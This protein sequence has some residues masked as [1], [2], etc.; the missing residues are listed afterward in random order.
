MKYY[1][2]TTVWNTDYA[3]PNH[4]YYMRDDKQY[5]VGYIPV[6]S[7]KLVKFRKPMRIETKGRKFTV[8]P[9]AGEDDSVYFGQ[10]SESPAAGVITVEGSG[11]KKYYLSKVGSGW[12]CTCPGY[13][14]RR[15]CR[16]VAEQEN[17]K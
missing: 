9:K 12:R 2:E 16:H 5:A 8:L 11:G 3:V 4:I 7:K 14:F 15:N 13:T 17:I 10:E 1:Q 6:G